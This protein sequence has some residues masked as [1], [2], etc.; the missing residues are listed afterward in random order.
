MLIQPFC[1]TKQHVYSF[2]TALQC[3]ALSNMS[4]S[5]RITQCI[6]KVKKQVQQ[7]SQS[8]T[9]CTTQRVIAQST[10]VKETMH[11]FLNFKRVPRRFGQK[12]FRSATEWWRFYSIVNMVQIQNIKII[13]LRTNGTGLIIIIPCCCMLS[14]LELVVTVWSISLSK[15]TNMYT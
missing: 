15:L 13:E 10:Q 3:P 5:L 6:Q 11:P 4:C 14:C 1:L 9:L 8:N 2:I 7:Q 12:L